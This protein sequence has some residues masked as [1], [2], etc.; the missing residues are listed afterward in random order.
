MR[1]LSRKNDNMGKM[2]KGINYNC[3]GIRAG[4]HSSIFLGKSGEGAI[5]GERRQ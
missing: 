1:F 3:V 5:L 2:K 4:H